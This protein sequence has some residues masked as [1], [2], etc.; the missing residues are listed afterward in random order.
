MSGVQGGLR[1]RTQT[2]GAVFK[3]MRLG[4]AKGQGQIKKSREEEGAARRGEGARWEESLAALGGKVL[5]AQGRKS[6]PA[7]MLSRGTHQ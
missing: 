3:G 1:L 5:G 6:R 4:H 7:P 2:W